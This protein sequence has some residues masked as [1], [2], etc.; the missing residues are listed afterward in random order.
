MTSALSSTDNTA[1][2][3]L[4]NQLDYIL[5]DGSGSM[6]GQWWE[7]LSSIDTYMDELKTAQL[8]SQCILQVF[9]TT[10]LDYIARDCHMRDWKSFA[11]D[12]VGAHWGGTPLYDAIAVMGF[13]LRDLNPPKCSIAIVTDGKEVD[14]RFTTL[15]GA[16]AILDW[17]R[18]KGWQVTFLGANFNNS[19][20][21]RALG[22]NEATAIGVQKKLLADAA[23]SFAQKRRRYGTTGENINFSPEERQQFGGYLAAPE[24]K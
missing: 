20:Q 2:V 6:Q 15:D 5:L 22:A 11:T 13:R 3:P 4:T 9:D 21:A 7:V 19:A 23:K 8:D 12:P 24:G 10:D 1:L 18:A 14:S 16:K 17:C